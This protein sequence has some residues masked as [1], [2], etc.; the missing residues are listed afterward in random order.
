MKNKVW[1]VCILVIFI[2]ITCLILFFVNHK[3]VANINKFHKEMESQQYI[4]KDITSSYKNDL[5]IIKVINAIKND[6]TYQISFFEYNNEE[7]A[8]LGYSHNL[9][10]LETYKT[11]NNNSEKKTSNSHY[12]KC[13]L[14]TGQK[15]RILY[16]NKNNVIFV[17]G[18]IGLKDEI[19][20]VL[21][22]YGL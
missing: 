8:K 9:K 18:N 15:Y 3:S 7:N 4:V 19:N 22:K 21:S 12:E 11:S 13:E 16:R 14:I 5:N 2:V 20:N 1:P 6:Y 10:N 17:D